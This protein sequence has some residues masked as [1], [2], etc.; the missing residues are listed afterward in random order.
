[1]CDGN[2]FTVGRDREK[3]E[4]SR[5]TVVSHDEAGLLIGLD[6]KSD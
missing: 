4:S 3:E 2:S 1:M 5:S 6:E